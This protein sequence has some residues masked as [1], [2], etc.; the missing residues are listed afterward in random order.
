MP[1]DEVK[2][3]LGLSYQ[4]PVP[5]RG[6]MTEQREEEM[7][8]GLPLLCQGDGEGLAETYTGRLSK[9]VPPV[10]KILN[11]LLQLAEQDGE[12]GQEGVMIED[13]EVQLPVCPRKSS[14]E[15]EPGDL[16][17]HGHSQTPVVGES[18]VV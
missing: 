2:L 7:L 9:I 3:F 15:L 5:L 4:D 16:Q 18:W 6:C 11:L 10:S 8:E 1:D 17:F 14:W 12:L 13:G